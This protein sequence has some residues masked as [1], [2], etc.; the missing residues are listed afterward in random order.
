MGLLRW[1]PSAFWEATPQD[2]YAAYGAWRRVTGQ[3]GDMT[4]A[5]LVAAYDEMMEAERDG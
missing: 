5:E 3:D 4:S 2:V 1:S